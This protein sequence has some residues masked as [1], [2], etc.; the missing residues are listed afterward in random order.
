MKRMVVSS[1]RP[2]KFVRSASI[3]QMI[4][5]IENAKAELNRYEPEKVEYV[6]QCMQDIMEEI[7]N[8]YA[9]DQEV[10]NINLSAIKTDWML[11][12]I[13]DDLMTEE[14]FEDIFN[15]LDIIDLEYA[16]ANS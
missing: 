10:E 13:E 16:W 4:R 11:G 15:L 6:Q 3:A 2:R 5:D 1:T 7:N 14:E 12:A 8:Y 9:E